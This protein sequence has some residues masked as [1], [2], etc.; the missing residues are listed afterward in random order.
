MKH[1]ITLVW[2]ISVQLMQSNV[3]LLLLKTTYQVICQI[4]GAIKRYDWTYIL[5]NANKEYRIYIIEIAMYPT[6]LVTNHLC[7]W[8][9]MDH[10]DY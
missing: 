8:P 9:V 2:K 3:N 7:P 1:K 6:W 10:R 5:Q 4:V